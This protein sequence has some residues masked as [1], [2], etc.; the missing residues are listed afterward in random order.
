DK[1]VVID[2]IQRMPE[3]FPLIR[4]LIDKKREYARFLILGS[5]SP[6]LIR[7]S[8]ESLAGR[9]AYLELH[10]FNIT[11]IPAWISIYDHWFRGGFPEALLAP[12]LGLSQKWLDNFIKTYI[13]RDLPILG[14]QA[15]NI[16]IRRLWTML[17]HINGQLLNYSELSKSLGISIPTVKNYIDF[18]E[19]AFLIYRLYPFSANLKKRLIKTPKIYISDT[20]IIHRLLSINSPDELYGHISV[21]GSWENYAIQQLKQKAGKNIQFYFYRTHDG[22]ECDLVLIKGNTPIMGI[23]IKYTSTPYLNKGNII[24]FEDLRTP[25]N[26]IITPESDNYTIRKN[27]TVCNLKTFIEKYLPERE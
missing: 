10:P 23:D 11:E 22:S 14:L 12:E 27:V 21:G 16:L 25:N 4:A 13:E 2:E 19:Q 5:A 8:S 17:A 24:A 3:L 9:I 26:F 20:G 6:A 18:L 15:S 7:E 1:C